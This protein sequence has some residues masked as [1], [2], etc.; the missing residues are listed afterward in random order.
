MASSVD[1]R[2]EAYLSRVMG[3]RD[4][5]GLIRARSTEPIGACGS[6]PRTQAGHMTASD[7][8][9]PNAKKSLQAGG[10][11][12]MT[13]P[14]TSWLQFA[15]STDVGGR[16]KPGHGAFGVKRARQRIYSAAS[17]RSAVTDSARS[18]STTSQL[19]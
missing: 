14:S 12:H 10:H 11:P 2:I 17:A 9:C 5:A 1:R 3:Q 18:F 4:P 19:R 6:W 13:R 15:A 16:V 8:S 7:Q